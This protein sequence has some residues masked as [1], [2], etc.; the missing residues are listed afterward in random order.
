MSVIHAELCGCQ[1]LRSYTNSIIDY[2]PMH[3][4]APAMLAAA[5]ET[6]A[7][8]EQV[9]FSP[10]PGIYDTIS[11]FALESAVERAEDPGDAIAEAT[12]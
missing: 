1:V 9:D 2:C 6:L 4:A 8:L 3:R 12:H 11:W 5:K 7:A 10:L